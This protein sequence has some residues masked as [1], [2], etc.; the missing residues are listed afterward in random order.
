MKWPE[1]NSWFIYS[2][3]TV[4]LYFRGWGALQTERFCEVPVKLDWAYWPIIDWFHNESTDADMER[5]SRNMSEIRGLEINSMY[6]WFLW[7]FVL[8]GSPQE[9]CFPIM[10]GEPKPLYVTCDWGCNRNPVDN[11]DKPRTPGWWWNI[12]YVFTLFH[13]IY[14]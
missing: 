6:A 12:T 13:R 11:W 4:D 2:I 14:F 10:V 1:A 5:S 9:V 8:C 7:V 3:T